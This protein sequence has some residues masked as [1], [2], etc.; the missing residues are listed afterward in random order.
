LKISL[1]GETREIAPGTTL[2]QLV[3]GLSLGGVKVAVERNFNIVP[4]EQY[5]AT[6]LVEGDRIEVVTFVG[7]G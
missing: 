7:G 3:A 5:D 6:V 4:R 1:N 2:S